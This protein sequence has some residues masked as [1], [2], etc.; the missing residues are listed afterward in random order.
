MNT[1]AINFDDIR[2][3]YGIAHDYDDAVLA[4]FAENW[5]RLEDAEWQGFEDSYCGDWQGFNDDDAIGEYLH[6]LAD[7]CGDLVNIPEYIRSNID[8]SA[9]GR[10]ARFG[11]EFR[12]PRLS[13][14]VFAVF[15]NW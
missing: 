10:D 15:R 9:I 2:A 11:G 5:F 13:C 3:E 1:K 12:A 4:A 8:W 7:G 6:D 14:G